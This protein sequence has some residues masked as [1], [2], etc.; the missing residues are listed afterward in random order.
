MTIKINRGGSGLPPR[1]MFW[2]IEGGGKTSI[3]AQFPKPFFLL[4]RGETGILT[5]QDA[6]LVDQEIASSDPVNSW[7]DLQEIV[8]Y[9]L[10]DEHDHQT[11]VV[12]TVTGVEQIYYEFILAAE[13]RNSAEAF[14]AYGKNKLYPHNLWKLFIQ[15]LELIRTTRKMQ[16]ILLGH[17]KVD[18][19]SDPST[20]DYNRYVPRFTN[21]PCWDLVYAWLDEC[22]F[23]HRETM[24][25]K[26]ELD[27]GNRATDLGRFLR[28]DRQPAWDAKTR[29]GIP[30]KIPM[31][32]SAQEAYATLMSAY[33]SA[34]KRKKPNN[35]DGLVVDGS[36][37]TGEHS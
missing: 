19:F 23:L 3:A 8:G 30:S 16:I 33:A 18:K 35:I 6:G 11:L 21:Q 2:G 14:S 9:L 10:R 27:R 20:G 22:L 5:L 28:S 26:A 34:M 32:S 17:G 25:T 1:M 15:Q 13:F 7:N 29:W 24:T 12:D 4:S 31:G 36:S 37:K